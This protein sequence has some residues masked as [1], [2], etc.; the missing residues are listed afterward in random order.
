[1]SSTQFLSQI[2]KSH[3]NKSSRVAKELANKIAN[4]YAKNVVIQDEGLLDDGRTAK[5][6][7]ILTN[8]LQYSQQLTTIPTFEVPFE[9]DHEF[10]TF[11]IKA[12]HTGHILQDLSFFDNVISSN[13]EKHI[14]LVDG[15]GLDVGYLGTYNGTA[16]SPAWKANGVDETYKVADNINLQSSSTSIGFSVTAWV[17]VSDF[18][19]HDGINRRIL[20]KMDDSNDAY[21]LFVTPTQHAVWAMQFGGTEYKV[22]TSTTLDPDTWYFIAAT[23]DS[24]SPAA[25]IYLNGTA[26]TTSYGTAISYPTNDSDLYLFCRESFGETGDYGDFSGY[27]RDVRIYREK[28]LSQTE[29]TNFN[30]NRNTISDIDLG[31][32]MVAG[33]VWTDPDTSASSFTTTSFT[34]DSFNT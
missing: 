20:S 3:S 7:A 13:N 30:T 24:D 14:C 8:K 19:Q 29:I 9:P 27:I 28:V 6:R 17:K 21:T 31:S 22:Q 16:S 2:R 5:Q 33:Y 11:W 10:L 15:G 1:M 34:T 26:S 25:T 32:V 23:F 4:L 18:E 12:N